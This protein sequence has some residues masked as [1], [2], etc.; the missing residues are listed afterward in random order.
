[1]RFKQH[2]HTWAKVAS[3]LDTAGLRWQE[4]RCTECGRLTRA[5]VDRRG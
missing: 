4:Q 1:L 5:R 3:W 2:A